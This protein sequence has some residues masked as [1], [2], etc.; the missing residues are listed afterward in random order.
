MKFNLFVLPFT[1]GL[2]VLFSILTAKYIRWFLS[3]ST[4]QRDAVIKNFFTLKTLSGLREIFLES[5]LH[6]N[7]SRKNRLL[8]YMHMSLAFGWFLLIIVGHFESYSYFKTALEPPYIPIFLRY[9]QQDSLADPLQVIYWFV[10]DLILLFVLSGVALAWYKRHNRKHFGMKKTTRHLPADRIALSV[11]WFIFPLRLLA[12]SITSAIYGG[13]SFLTSGLGSLLENNIASDLSFIASWWAYSI[14]L[15]LFFVFLPFSRYMHIPT[16]VVL[17]MLRNWGA[18]KYTGKIDGITQFEVHSCS[19]CGICLDSCQLLELGHANIQSP[20]L[21]RNFRGNKL[22][23]TVVQ[24]CLMCGRCETTCVVGIKTNSVRRAIRQNSDVE[25]NHDYLRHVDTSFNSSPDVLYF[26]GCMTHLTPGI[27]KS[28]QAIFKAAK[29]NYALV[30]EDQ[31]ICC[32]RPMMLSGLAEQSLAMVNK[33]KELFENSGAQT[34]V[35]SCPICYKVFRDEY[36]LNIEVLHHTQ[37]IDRLMKEGKLALAKSEEQVVYHDPCELGRNSGV[38]DEPRRVIAALANLSES[39][40]NRE[41]AWC[42]GGSIANAMLT[43]L[44]KKELAI[45]ALGKIVP[46]NTMTLVTACPL[47]K[48]TF[49]STGKHINIVDIAELVAVNLSAG[50]DKRRIWMFEKIESASI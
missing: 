48:K 2:L 18:T 9:F 41:K 1:I 4:D 21:F 45:S 10:M 36:N 17:I 29:I 27:K 24:N 35:T 49:A 20:Y 50:K 16:E 33:N 43:S 11:L 13:G 47:C 26:A 42:C 37:Y 14:S 19:S 46:K 28:M 38:Y 5:L 31:N 40:A 22:S 32:G 23:D 15:G 34:L 39:P 44:E 8:G 7:I 25:V 30:D 6:R 3:L 12:E